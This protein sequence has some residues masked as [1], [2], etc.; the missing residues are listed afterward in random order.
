[1]KALGGPRPETV[2]KGREP[3]I[4]PSHKRGRSVGGKVSYE[5][6]TTTPA[7]NQGQASHSC[8]PGPIRIRSAVLL[9]LCHI[10]KGLLMPQMEQNQPGN[11][12]LGVAQK[13]SA[14]V[15]KQRTKR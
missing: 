11:C 6:G 9:W 7:S 2:K 15:L 4:P 8:G 10:K 12:E 5:S 1:V 13:G 14:C 3:V